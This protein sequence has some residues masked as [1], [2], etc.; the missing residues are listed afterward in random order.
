MVVSSVVPAKAGTQSLP[1]AQAGGQTPSRQLVIEV[2]PLRIIDLDQFELP[3]APPF[4]DPL[5]AQDRVRHGLVKF[6]KDQAGDAVVP[7]K[8]GN[9][10]RPMLPNTA[11][12]VGRYA[13]VER[14]VASA[15][16]GRW[17]GPIPMLSRHLL[18]AA[19]RGRHALGASHRPTDRA[20]REAGPRAAPA[21]ECAGAT[22]Q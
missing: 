21:P 6:G 17:V 12:K 5:F 1:L 22:P 13:N 18:A 14:T 8:A 20:G 4:L 7:D 9:R 11:S 15:R 16:K 3:G 10:I 2:A 19:T